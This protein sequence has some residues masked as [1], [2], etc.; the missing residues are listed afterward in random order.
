MNNYPIYEDEN[1]KVEIDGDFHQILSFFKVQQIRLND[2]EEEFF[3]SLIKQV[4]FYLNKIGVKK[5]TKVV[6][7]ANCVVLSYD[8]YVSISPPFDVFCDALDCICSDIYFTQHV[9]DSL[10]A[11]QTIYKEDGIYI[12]GDVF[13]DPT[14]EFYG[15]LCVWDEEKTQVKVLLYGYNNL[16]DI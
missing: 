12:G 8:K 4:N 15:F 2:L 7:S 11:I 16:L 9:K 13:K 6:Y 5:D 10:Y 1:M 14:T 3:N